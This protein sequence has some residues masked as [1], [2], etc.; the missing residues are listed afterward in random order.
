MK[1][2]KV[3][4]INSRYNYSLVK[5]LIQSAS[6][7]LNTQRS[8]MQASIVD[9]PGAFEIPITIEKYIK[10]FDGII[11]LGCIIKGETNNFDLISRSITDALMQLSL[12]HKKPI[13]NGI[14]TCFNNKQA[15]ARKDKGREA[16]VAVQT[17]L[18][19]NITKI[20]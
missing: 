9:V 3:L 10:Q 14:I 12:K 4:I 18:S 13:G 5:G 17:V 7:Q 1:K 15:Y 16:V 8:W 6:K 2:K 11:A 19:N 20:G